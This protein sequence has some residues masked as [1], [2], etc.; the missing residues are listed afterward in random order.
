VNALA[1]T[2]GG[3]LTQQPQGTVQVA[4]S[5]AAQEVQAAMIIAQR[6][7]RD[8][9]ASQKRINDACSRESMAEVSQYTYPR[10]GKQITGASIRL[11]EVLAQNWGNLD[12][13][14][15]ELEKENGNSKMMAYCWDLETNVKQTKV[16]DVPH[17]RYTKKNGVTSLDDPRD[18]YEAT[19]NQG[20]RRLR[21]CILGIIPGDIVEEAIE[22][23][24]KTLADPHGKPPIKDRIVSM[25]EKFSRL[26]VNQKM[27]EKRIG[28]K[29]DVTTEIE[30]V[31]LGKIYIS[32]KDNY[33]DRSQYFDLNENSRTPIDIEIQERSEQ[34]NVSEVTEEPKPQPQKLTLKQVQ[35][36]LGG[37]PLRRQVLIDALRDND[38]N[39]SNFDRTVND[40][41][42]QGKVY[43]QED[44]ISETQ[45]EN[46][47]QQDSPPPV[48]EETAPPAEDTPTSEILP[49]AQDILD[50]I[51]DAGSISIKEL[52]TKAKVENMDIEY[53]DFDKHLN[54]LESDMFVRFS[55]DSEGTTFVER[56]GI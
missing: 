42:K 35:L 40:W 2:E 54:S 10:G 26:G 36:V 7:P 53:K 49:E 4:Q 21:A 25:L 46:E 16:F 23:C 19:A 13:G 28:H 27:I 56:T 33:A 8:T 37:K 30:L 39:V 50:K 48:D 12:F 14:I 11:A 55:K 18:I 17:A 20:A 38:V 31:N 24:N 32:L 52:W 43:E 51:P 41:V 34:R 9:I 22:R 1:T 47:D 29:I 45:F 3:F 15:V 44:V 5:R 6:F